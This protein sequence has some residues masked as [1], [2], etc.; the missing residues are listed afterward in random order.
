MALAKPFKRTCRQVYPVD[1]RTSYIA[2][3]RYAIAPK[4]FIR[5]FELIQ[6][7]LLEL[8]DYVEPADKNRECYSFRILELL[9]RTCI[10]VEANCKAILEENGYTRPGNWNMRDDYFKLN[11]THRLSSYEVKFPVW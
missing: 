11:L 10:E 9:L 4:Q 8:F 1:I 5:A 3:P 2:D 6:K 7:D